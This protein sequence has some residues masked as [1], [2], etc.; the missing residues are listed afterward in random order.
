MSC[1]V[2]LAVVSFHHSLADT[3]LRGNVLFDALGRFFLFLLPLPAAC[4][5]A[6]VLHRPT[7]AERILANMNTGLFKKL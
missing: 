3:V 5:F 7:K 1:L 2:L 4:S 6:T